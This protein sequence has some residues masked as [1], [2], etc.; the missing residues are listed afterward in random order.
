MYVPTPRRIGSSE[1]LQQFDRRESD[2]CAT[3]RREFGEPI[4]DPG[5]AFA[6]WRVSQ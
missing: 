5:L 4:D 6:Y 2:F 3:V 1:T